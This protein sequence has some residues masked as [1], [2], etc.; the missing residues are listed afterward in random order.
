MCYSGG[1]EHTESM[2]R[3]EILSAIEQAS[4]GMDHR[5]GIGSLAG[6]MDAVADLAEAY[7]DGEWDREYLLE[8]LMA[9]HD[10]FR[11][12]VRRHAR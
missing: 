2:G 9:A 5:T 3:D 10:R 1:M 6:R 12:V 8:S 4:T 11:N 7:V